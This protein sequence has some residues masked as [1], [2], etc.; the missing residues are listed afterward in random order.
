[1]RKTIFR[2]AAIF[3]FVNQLN[4]LSL[5]SDIDRAERILPEFQIPQPILNNSKGIVIMSYVKA[6]FIWSGKVGSGLVIAHRGKTWSAPSG[7]GMGGAG[8]GLQIGA[9]VTDFVLVLNSDDAVNAFADG[10]SVTL[11]GALSV[12]A[13][14]VG[15]TAEGSVAFPPGAIYYYG[16]SQGLFAGVSLEGA[17]LFERRKDNRQFYGKSVTPSELFSGKIPPPQSAEALY[18]ILNGQ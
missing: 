15:A 5:Q 12:V 10:G 3:L 17:V 11:G 14:P 4:A 2:L 6:G 9:N 1:M 18:K 8:W 13:G 7:I 16:I